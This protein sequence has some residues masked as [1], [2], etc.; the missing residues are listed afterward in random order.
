MTKNQEAKMLG[1]MMI[2]LNK[3]IRGEVEMEQG[4]N[5]NKVQKLADNICER[6]MELTTEI[7]KE[8]GLL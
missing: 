8:N 2:V 6:L 1:E 3:M 5:K 4:W 7:A